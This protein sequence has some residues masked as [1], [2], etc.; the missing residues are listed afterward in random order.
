MKDDFE[1]V[2]LYDP[3]SGHASNISV[4]PNT[5]A[6]VFIPMEQYRKEVLIG[7]DTKE[8]LLHQMMCDIPRSRVS[9]DGKA[10]PDFDMKELLDLD[11][12]QFVT[13][14]CMAIPVQMLL[15]GT[16]QPVFE[17]SPQRPMK[18]NIRKGDV[19]CHK[20]LCVS[21]SQDRFCNVDI[22][23]FLATHQPMA[24]IH[25]AFRGPKTKSFCLD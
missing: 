14:T 6:T 7:Q 19:T 2:D 16:S 22:T 10:Y 1:I 23:I 11:L 9:M 3:C 4:A 25:F 21:D 13:Q 20:R 5:R 17:S 15:S 12:A 24:S 8:R 18:V